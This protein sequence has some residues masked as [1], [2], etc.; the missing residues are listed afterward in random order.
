MKEDKRK[1]TRVPLDFDISVSL[2]RKQVGVEGLNISMTGMLCSAGPI[3]K[4]DAACRITIRLADR[5]RIAVAGKIT[6]SGPDG[7]AIA[8]T[9]MSAMSFSHLKKLI[10]YNLGNADHIN[11]EL[12][13]PAFRSAK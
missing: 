4:K 3:F 10:Q 8:F 9:S 12:R 11:R 6:R 2:G 1:R 5:V 13:V 7:T